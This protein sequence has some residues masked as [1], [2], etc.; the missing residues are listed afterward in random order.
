[1]LKRTTAF[2]IAIILTTACFS[3]GKPASGILT[4]NVMDEKNKALEGATVQ[5]IALPDSQNRKAVTADKYGQFTFSGIDFGY[6]KLSISFI[7]HQTLT[8]DSVYFRMERYDFNLSDII[9]KPRTSDNLDAVVVYAE[10][11]LIQSKDG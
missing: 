1:M 10:K 8:I 4:G 7:G 9:L 2:V 11:P 6:Y 3:Q 5:L